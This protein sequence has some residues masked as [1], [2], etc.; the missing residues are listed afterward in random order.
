M[1][2][3]GV[4]ITGLLVGLLLFGQN[5]SQSIEINGEISGPVDSMPQTLRITAYQQQNQNINDIN[6][7]SNGA[8]KLNLFVSEPGLVSI[9]FPKSTFNFIVTP[10]QKTYKVIATQQANRLFKAE[11]T[12]STENAAFAL[13]ENAT[14]K[15]LDQLNTYL[16]NPQTETN[17]TE[18][19]IAFY[20]QL[21][22]IE[23]GY[24]GTFTANTL[25][26]A[27][28]VGTPP[29]KADSYYYK[30]HLLNANAFNNTAFYNTNYPTNLFLL[31]SKYFLVDNATDAATWYTGFFGNVSD[32]T[33]RNRLHQLLYTTYYNGQMEKQLSNYTDWVNTN[34]GMV[35][36]LYVKHQA[37][38][39]A[40][41]LCGKT[42][43][44]VAEKNANGEWVTL[45]KTATNNK[46]TLLTIWS[47][48]C[49]H[50]R[51]DIPLLNP[52][53][54]KYHQQGL[55]IFS[56][57]VNSTEQ[58][59]KEFSEKN[60]IKWQNT[61]H[62]MGTPYGSLNDYQITTIPAFIAI[63]QNGRILRRFVKQEQIEDLM[64]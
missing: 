52:I 32:S 1:K 19:T 31:Y 55:E 15:F 54:E 51:H 27:F 8:F 17:I 53:Y 40:K 47:P 6:I 50:C 11:V 2:K 34:P 21:Q 62:T 56:V 23:T 26:Q 30:T 49:E 3:I 33:A 18:Q 29:K 24:K 12:Q 7:D 25:T 64:K 58:E 61:Y 5:N 45:Q 14:A 22:K 9:T 4:L 37:G 63:D 57:A 20:K 41:V 44:D 10:N 36:N 39:I 42:A 48:T 28:A 46:V 35:N 38:L 43:P 16:Q 13:F 59:W 60:G